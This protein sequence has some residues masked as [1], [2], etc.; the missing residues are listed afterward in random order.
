MTTTGWFFAAAI[1]IVI[2]LICNTQL[3]ESKKSKGTGV[4]PEP[5]KDN[6]DRRDGDQV[7]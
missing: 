2:I 1:I 7:N 5:K 6:D 4:A 3:R